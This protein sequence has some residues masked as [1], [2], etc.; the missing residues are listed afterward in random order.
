MAL[1]KSNAEEEWPNSDFDDASDSEVAE[2]LDWLNTVE[3]PDDSAQ[4]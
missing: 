3:G 4:P 2:A 1:M